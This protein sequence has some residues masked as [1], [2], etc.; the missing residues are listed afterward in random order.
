LLRLICL[1]AQPDHEHAA[2]VGVACVS[3]Q[4]SGQDAIALASV[5][6]AT[7]TTL[8]QGDDAVDIEPLLQSA[9][10]VEIFCDVLRHGGGAVHG[11]DDRDVVA[12]AGVSVRPRVAE[13]VPAL[14]CRYARG[15]PIVGAE[16]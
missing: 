8:R 6:D 5:I 13:E 3:L 1:A 10:M 4:G 11:T 14:R 9:P 12:R 7:T 15:R 2:D 16:F